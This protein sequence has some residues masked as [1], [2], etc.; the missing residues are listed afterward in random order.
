MFNKKKDEDKQLAIEHGKKKNLHKGAD[1]ETTKLDLIEKSRKAGWLAFGASMFVSS[2][3]ASAIVVMTPLKKTEYHLLSVDRNTGQTEVIS[4]VDKK[5]I[6]SDFANNS[7]W[8]TRYV[9]TRESYNYMSLQ[10]DYENTNLFSS[11]SVFSQYSEMYQG[12]ESLH[13]R[14]GRKFEYVVNILGV[15]P[16]NSSTYQ[17]RFNKVKRLS[18][19][20]EVKEERTWIATISFEYQPKRE[21]TVGERYINPFGFT[22]LSYRLTPES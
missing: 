10:A 12:E 3:L 18:N 21:L 6:D 13:N 9:V 4:V 5:E 22:V 14:M 16:Q 20:L 8:L 19:S 7:H 15:V 1:L 2:L 11:S 17:V